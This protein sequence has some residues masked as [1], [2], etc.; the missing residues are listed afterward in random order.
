MEGVTQFID[1]GSMDVK[2][3]GK[4]VHRLGDP[5]LNNCDDSGSP[6][7]AATLPGILQAPVVVV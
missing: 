1:L 5:M 6:A 3:E 4:N 2:I 7:N